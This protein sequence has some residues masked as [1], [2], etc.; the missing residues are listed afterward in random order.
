ME[1]RVAEVVAVV[2]V[3]RG[4][5]LAQ[6]LE[7]PAEGVLAVGVAE[8]RL[9]RERPRTHVRQRSVVREHQVAPVEHAHERMR[10]LYPRRAQ[11][12]LADV[13]DGQPRLDRVVVEEA[14]ERAGVGGVLLTKRARELPFVEGD[15]PAVGVRAR[16]PAALEEAGERE[17]D[18]DRLARRDAQQLAHEKQRSNDGARGPGAI[19]GGS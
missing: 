4:V 1:H 8:R 7:Q 10:V 2:R 19:R 5:A 14:R 17:R 6:A 16:P 3:P 11:G 12:L 13:R 15:A 18:V 9:M